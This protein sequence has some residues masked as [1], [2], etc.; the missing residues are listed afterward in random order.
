MNPLHFLG[1][2]FRG[3]FSWNFPIK[4][5]GQFFSWKQSDFLNPLHLAEFYVKIK[6]LK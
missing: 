1:Q 6:R 4:N 5:F 3:T 2:I